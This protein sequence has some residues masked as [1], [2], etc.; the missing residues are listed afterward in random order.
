M[1]SSSAALADLLG[2]IVGVH[3]IEDVQSQKWCPKASDELVPHNCDVRE[4]KDVE[5]TMLAPFAVVGVGVVK[6]VR[7]KEKLKQIRAA[8]T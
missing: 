5:R 3:G 8:S 6:G 2:L 1:H 4:D 7:L